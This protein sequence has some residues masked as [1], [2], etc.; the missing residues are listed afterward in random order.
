MKEGINHIETDW[1]KRWALYSPKNIALKSVEDGTELSY[2]DLYSSINRVAALL[3][4]KYGVSKGDRVA[5]LSI[6]RIEY[7][8]LFFAIQKLGAIMLPL[9]YR[10]AIPELTYQ[11]QDADVKLFVYETSF[12]DTIK[13]VDHQAEA[14]INFDD[15][16]GLSAIMFATSEPPEIESRSE[17]DD[18]CMILYTSGTTGRPKGAVITNKMLFWNSTNTGLRLNLTQ[19]D[20]SVTFAPFF[21][22]GGWNVLTTPLLHRGATVLLMK[23]FDPDTILKLCDEEEVTILFGVPTMMDMMFRSDEF[24]NSSLKTVRYAIVGGEPMPLKL[25]EAWQD[26]GI[27]VRQGYGLTEFGPNVFSL[28]QEDSKRKIGSIGFPNFY[29]DTRVVDD[30]GKDVSQGKAGELILKGPVCMKEYWKN[31]E[32]TAKT[33]VNGWLHTGDIVQVDEDGYF[34]V[35][36]RKKEMFISGAENVYPAEVEHV[37]RQHPDVRDIAVIGV[38]D[39]KWGESGKAFIV[40][41]EDSSVTAE[42]FL[43]WGKGQLAKFKVPKHYEFIKELPKSDSGKILKKALKDR[44]GLK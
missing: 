27:P 28:N 10:L 3:T 19:Q 23:K 24:E 22:T 21:H 41:N 36:D 26:K 6:N 34:Y 39:E 8:V 17:F 31:P 5:V 18:P 32:A 38:P 13:K 2:K 29:I 43:S 12:E 30:N 35:I 25:I 44:E 7:V 11:L 1:I 20:V 14:L 9:N 15:Q 42:D 33:V 4:Q 40:L 37:F 16:D